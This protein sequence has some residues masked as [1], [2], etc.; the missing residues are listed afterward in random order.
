MRGAGGAAGTVTATERLIVVRL[1]EQEPGALLSL[2]AGCLAPS[3]APVEVASGAIVRAET[4]RRPGDD[5]FLI[6]EDEFSFRAQY[7]SREEQRVLRCRVNAARAHKAGHVDDAR[8][9]RQQADRLE[10]KLAQ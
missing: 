5:P 6:D 7:M 3:V 9:F 8:Q 1:A 2:L 4:E 10:R